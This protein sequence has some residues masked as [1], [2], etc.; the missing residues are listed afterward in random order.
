MSEP[1]QPSYPQGGYPQGYQAGNP[2]GYPEQPTYP[3]PSPGSMGRVALIVAIVALVI[4]LVLT[5]ITPFVVTSG[6]PV[7]VGML[8]LF[9]AII[10]TVVAVTGLILGIIGI[11]RR[12][13]PVLAGIAVGITAAIVLGVASG[14]LTGVLYTIA[15]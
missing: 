6:G 7:M 10:Q 3:Q 13:Q 8:N 12:A 9:S 2:Q 14:L 15:L 5:V 4:G 11:S 1:Q